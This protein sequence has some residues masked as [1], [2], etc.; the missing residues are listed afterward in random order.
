MNAVTE[1]Y[2]CSKTTECEQTEGHRSVWMATED[3]GSGRNSNNI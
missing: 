2:K 1:L 3:S